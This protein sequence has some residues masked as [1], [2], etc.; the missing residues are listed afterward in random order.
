VPEET[1]P[2]AMPWTCYGVQNPIPAM[3]RKG[4]DE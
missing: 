3:A 2:E 4:V 1:D